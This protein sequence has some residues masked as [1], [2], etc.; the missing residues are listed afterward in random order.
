MPEVNVQNND[1]LKRRLASLYKYLSQHLGIKEVPKVVFR[2][3]KK[4]ADD[5]LGMTGHYDP[6]TKTI[7]LY[8]TGRHPK[9]LL[10]SY[11]HELIH[12]WQ[13]ENGTLSSQSEKASAHYA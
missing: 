9:D 8:I 3:S 1:G 5:M 12:H 4:N 13:N 2:N 7:V 11:C 6:Q 10:R